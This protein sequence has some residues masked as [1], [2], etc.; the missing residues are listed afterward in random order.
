MFIYADESGNSGRN[1]LKKMRPKWS[2]SG[3]TSSCLADLLSAKMLLHGHRV[4]GAAFHRGVIGH[5]QALHPLHA[6][7]ARDEAGRWR[8]VPIHAVGRELADLEERRARID[9]M[10]DTLAWQ[11]FAARRVL[12]LSLGAAATAHRGRADAQIVDQSAHGGS[13][14]AELFRFRIDEGLQGLHEAPPLTGFRP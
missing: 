5:D 1:L 13:I 8:I 2:R 12:G 4:T 3:N 7:D 10:V 11:E 14:G 6:A 9:E